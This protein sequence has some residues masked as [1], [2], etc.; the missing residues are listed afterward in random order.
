MFCFNHNTAALDAT[1][2]T[3][4]STRDFD[5]FQEPSSSVV[6]P[7]Y[8]IVLMVLCSTIILGAFV[9]FFV[10][11]RIR[12]QRFHQITLKQQAET[13]KHIYM[14]NPPNTRMYEV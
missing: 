8:V 14:N 1:N 3:F 12:Y 11:L 6:E 5:N 2:V 13:K 7:L 4:N 10:L 9:V